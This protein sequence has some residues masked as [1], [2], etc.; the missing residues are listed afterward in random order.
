V[1]RFCHWPTGFQLLL[2]DSRDEGR[3]PVAMARFWTVSPKSGPIR[4]DFDR[5]GQIP[6]SFAGIWPTQIPLKIPAKLAEFRPIYVESGR[7]TFLVSS[8][9]G[10]GRIPICF[11]EIQR[12]NTKIQEPSAIDSSYQQTS[13]PSG[14]GFPQTFLQ[15]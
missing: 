9:L 2:Q 15:E 8:R 3:N 14:G 10:I 6:A 1:T 12:S 13:M 11:A 7:R 5:I 4:P